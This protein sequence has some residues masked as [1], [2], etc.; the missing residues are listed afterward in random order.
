M[1]ILEA[2]VGCVKGAGFAFDWRSLQIRWSLSDYTVLAVRRQTPRVLA[3]T[4]LDD[5]WHLLGGKWEMGEVRSW[6]TRKK[7]KKFLLQQPCSS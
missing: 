6:K 1:F 2:R 3:M 4:S 7:N 5:R